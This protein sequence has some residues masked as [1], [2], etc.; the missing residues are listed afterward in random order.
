MNQSPQSSRFLKRQLIALS[1]LAPTALIVLTAY[2]LQRST[3]SSS[4]HPP[5]PRT[6]ALVDSTVPKSSFPATGFIW[7]AG[8]SSSFDFQTRLSFEEDTSSFGP[9]APIT[10]GDSSEDAIS[11]TKTP[12]EVIEIRCSYHL[13]VL[14]VTDEIVTLAVVVSDASVL[15]A[16]ERS[17]NFESLVNSTAAVITMTTDGAVR[18]IAFPEGIPTED[19][20]FLGMIFGWDFQSR[21]GETS[22][23]SVEAIDAKS[24]AVLASY[25]THPDG[26]VSQARSFLGV[27]D[28]KQPVLTVS[29]FEG[30]PGRCW[31]DYLRG[32]ERSIVMCDGKPKVASVVHLSLD[33]VAP[34]RKPASLASVMHHSVPPQAARMDPAVP[35]R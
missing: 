12:D 11:A 9:Q 10:V 33:R 35:G 20:Q 19:R 1:I 31:L 21:S 32:Q 5:S 14:S 6:S 7:R 34:N 3:A 4:T 2:S 17:L 16:G 13:G 27:S 18:R 30:K 23:E 24:A 29:H 15:R 8:D 28:D 22:W 25:S 26:S